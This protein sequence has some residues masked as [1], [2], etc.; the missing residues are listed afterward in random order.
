MKKQGLDITEILAS[1]A[2]AVAGGVTAS[3]LKKLPIDSKISNAI[4]IVA[5]AM[6]PVLFPG[7]SLIQAVGTGMA[8]VGGQKLL[9]DVTGSSLIAGVDVPSVADDNAISGYIP[10]VADDNAISG[11]QVPSVANNNAINGVQ[12]PSVANNNAINGLET[13]NPDVVGMD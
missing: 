13:V 2:G 10:S 9:A 8:A 6:L 7:N 11:V 1:T 12:V 5:G 3:C 4:A